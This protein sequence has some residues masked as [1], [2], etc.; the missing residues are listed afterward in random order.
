M[1]Y[2]T[3][4]GQLKSGLKWLVMAVF[5]GNQ[6]GVFGEKISAGETFFEIFRLRKDENRP[7]IA[8]LMPS[9]AMVYNALIHALS[10]GNARISSKSPW[11][12]FFFALA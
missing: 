11:K 10:C 4:T 6:F 12:W 7:E 8:Q 3:K 2:G 9:W 1:H 5:G